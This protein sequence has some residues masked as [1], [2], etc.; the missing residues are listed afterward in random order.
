MEIRFVNPGEPLDVRHQTEDWTTEWVNSMTI[1]L[2]TLNGLEGRFVPNAG[3]IGAGALD[4]ADHA[5]AGS[6]RIDP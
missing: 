1:Q 2:D 5:G 6:P 4:E 3:S